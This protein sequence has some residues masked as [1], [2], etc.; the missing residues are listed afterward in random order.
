MKKVKS[1]LLTLFATAM[2]VACGDQGGKTAQSANYD[3]V[4]L[5][6]EITAAEGNPFVLSS[7]TQ[8]V[9][10]EGNEKMQRNAEFL[11]EF[12]Q[13]ST[14]IKPT[15]TTKNSDKNSI[16]LQ[17]GG[18]QNDNTEAYQ[19]VVTEN[20][21]VIDAVNEAGVFYAIQTL[22][23]AA[24]TGNN[25]SVSFAPIVINDAPRF[26]YRGMH[27]DIARH[28]QPIEFI[29]RYIDIIAL[30]NMN[31][32]H[33]HLTD[34]QGWRIEIKKY[35]GLTEKGSKRSGTMIEKKWGVYDNVPHGGFYTQEEIKDVVKYAADR[36]I[37]IIP[38]IDMPGH[39]LGALTADPEL[40]CTG[41]PYEV[42]KEWGV[43]DDVLCA[44]QEKTYEF[45]E[46][47]L[48]EVME[49]FPSEYIH[50]G[51]DES[52]KARWETCPRCQAKIKELGL[53]DDAKHKKEFYLQSYFT[54]R[55]EKFLNER[56][57]KLIGWDEILEGTLAPNATVMSWRG[58][59]GG[60]EAAQL[61]HDVIMTPN[62]HLYFD[63][64]QTANVENEPL[65][66]CCL[67]TV[68]N[69]YN[70]EPI[71]EQLKE[72]EKKHILGAQANLW[73]EYIKDSKQIEY[74][75][76]P[77]MAAL[78]EVQWIQPEKKD[79]K[80]FLGRLSRMILLYDKLG[81]NY[82]THIFDIQA[83]MTPNFETNALD[84]A[85][86]SI[87]DAPIYYT[88]D[89]TE[90]TE[91]STKYDGVFSIK[92][93]AELKAVAIRANGKKS[94]VFSEKIT[95]SKST[96]KPI[97][98][99][100]QPAPNYE[101]SGEGLLVDGLH[102]SDKNYRTGHWMGFQGNDL[103]A[104]IDL[105][106]PTEV[107]QADINCYVVTG[108]WVFDASEIVIESSDNG[109]DFTA[110]QKEQYPIAKNDHWTEVSKHEVK[111]MQPTTARYFRVTVKPSIMPDW[112]GG[113]GKK[114]FIFVD[115]IAL[116]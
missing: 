115:E 8:I 78:S 11:A 93:D 69:V 90:P 17:V 109:T 114:A 53:K 92:E 79:Y 1:L 60:I 58:I 101:Y 51:G 96:F 24:P 57:R 21:I 47:V 40:G 84:V 71:P 108:D 19:L 3:I 75:V 73:T 23:K 63:Y 6:V 86:T 31:K 100:T 66:I 104:V 37:T 76:L 55:V 34:D 18:I 65:A 82:A 42:A 107:T 13:L 72:N 52:P 74:M 61:G 59:A 35:P 105:L 50:I 99:L 2:L 81:Y 25:I 44:G 48:T 87:D 29:K 56:G 43:F 68:E 32:F 39:M 64:Y 54:E 27:L 106:E 77:R 49:L 116:K 10:P 112:H 20:Q 113:K 45:V 62:S 16:L 22:R 9:Y 4:P 97:S 28:F 14:G 103:I 30:H 26:A 5:P 88:L 102:G 38:E 36:Y 98:L 33:W 85:F 41:G 12:L 94:R 95:V 67:S 7:S 80:A 91:N 83:K 89:G 70:Y 15:V 111:L 46:D 110:V